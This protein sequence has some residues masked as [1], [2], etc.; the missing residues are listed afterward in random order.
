MTSGASWLTVKQLVYRESFYAQKAQFD[1]LYQPL[2]DWDAKIAAALTACR[3]TNAI[4]KDGGLLGAVAPFA[5]RA[6]DRKG[7][8]SS[9]A[10]NAASLYAGAPGGAPGAGL[11]PQGLGE[12]EWPSPAA[13]WPNIDLPAHNLL[14]SLMLA[15]A[16]RMA[17]PTH[18]ETP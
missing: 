16:G 5:H 18:P 8:G 14:D 9:G 3:Q 12:G 15:H 1:P 11:S 6:L 2:V 13:A 10:S 4:S 17:P 7:L